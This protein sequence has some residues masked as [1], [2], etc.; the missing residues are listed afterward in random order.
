MRL[1]GHSK[2][3][4]AAWAERLMV[5]PQASAPEQPGAGSDPSS[6]KMVRGGVGQPEAEVVRLRVSTGGKF[7]MVSRTVCQ[8]LRGGCATRFG[9]R[10]QRQPAPSAA[11]VPADTA[12]APHPHARP[13]P[14]RV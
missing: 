5:R 7:V 14:P 13:C 2:E 11:V 12:A 1:H 6:A 4:G 8:E 10:P 9:R 3:D